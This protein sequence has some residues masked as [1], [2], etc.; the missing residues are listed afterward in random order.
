MAVCVAFLAQDIG[1]QSHQS[2]LAGPPLPADSHLLASAFP[3]GV[4]TDI[5]PHFLRGL[6]HLRFRPGETKATINAWLVI[7]IN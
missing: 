5:L 4:G 1:Q 7:V 3:F 6:N 2:T